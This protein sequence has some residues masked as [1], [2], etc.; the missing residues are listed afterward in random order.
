MAWLFLIAAGLFEIGLAVGLKYTAAFA[1]LGPAL[2]TAACVIASMVLLGIAVRTIPIG[3][4][5]AVWTGIGTLGTAVV[6][7][8]LFGEAATFGRFACIMLI[9]VGAVGLHLLPSE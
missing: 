2:A 1:R 7:V 5:Y 8:T 6:G 3:T 4:A 9:V